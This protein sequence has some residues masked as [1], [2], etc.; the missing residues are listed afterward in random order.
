LWLSAVLPVLLIPSLGV[1]A[2]MFYCFLFVPTVVGVLLLNWFN[3]RLVKHH[4][5]VKILFSIVC[6]LT[7]YTFSVTLIGVY[8][9]CFVEDAEEKSFGFFARRF[10]PHEYDVF[11]IFA[12]A[13]ALVIGVGYFIGPRQRTAVGANN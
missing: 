13:L 9:Y 7:L 10:L 12:A 5:V 8:H 4:V 11:Y 2:V 1:Y 6:L 3:P